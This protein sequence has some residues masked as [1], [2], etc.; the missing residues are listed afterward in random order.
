MSEGLEALTK[1]VKVVMSYR[2]DKARPDRK[3]PSPKVASHPGASA[4][5][6]PGK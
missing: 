4:K 5:G 2:P 1:L 6:G 3:L